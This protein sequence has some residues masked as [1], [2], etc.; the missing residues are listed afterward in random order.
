MTI[1]M[2]VGL[3]VTVISLMAIARGGGGREKMSSTTIKTN[4]K[5]PDGW[6]PSR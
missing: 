2:I 5:S 6:L 3:V 1:M 4:L